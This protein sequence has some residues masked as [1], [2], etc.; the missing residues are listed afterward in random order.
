MQAEISDPALAHDGP[1]VGFPGRSQRSLRSGVEDESRIVATEYLCL[2][3]AL[4]SHH[5][6]SLVCRRGTDTTIPVAGHGEAH[7]FPA[8]QRRLHSGCFRSV[9]WVLILPS[10]T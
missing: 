5:K 1:G 7:P 8:V 10:L 9:L 2:A 6:G 3:L 4:S